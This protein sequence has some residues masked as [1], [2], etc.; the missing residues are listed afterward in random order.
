MGLKNKVLNL[1]NKKDIENIQK[2]TTNDTK[3]NKTSFEIVDNNNYRIKADIKKWRYALNL[4][5]DIKYPNRYNLYQ[6]YDE[7]MLDPIVVNA[8]DLR[9]ERILGIPFSIVNKSG[10][11]NKKAQDVFSNYWFEKYIKFAIDSVLFGHSL[12]RIDGIDKN[13]VTDVSLIPR[14][15]IIPEFGVFKK[16]AQSNYSEAGTIDY[17]DNKIYK[18]FTEAFKSRNDVGLLNKVVVSQISKKVAQLAWTQF[19]EKFG[20]PTVI[21]RTNSNLET[22]KNDLQDFLTNLSMN[23]AAVLDK[24]TDIE[25]KETVRSD[26]YSVYKE[27]INTMNDEIN[28]AILGATELTS[29]ASG[30]SEARAKVHQ[31]QSNHKTA[32]DIRFIT[33]H[34]N[35]VLIPKLVKLK[36]IPTGLKFQFDFNEVLSMEEKITVDSQLLK[37]YKLSKDYIER[38][39]NVEI[40]DE[41]IIEEELITDETNETGETEL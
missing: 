22:E 33:N 10:K 16:D 11:V 27:L 25:F 3:L 14:E 8:I 38:V 9:T 2:T 12:I 36:V 5:E 6:I 21:G 13:G 37:Y 23:S 39:Y 1:F 26:V 40:E 4:A 35:N 29:G 20:E 32:S 7:I 28:T 41:P 30:G 15:N 18:W 17:M 31:A 34:I 24:Q 19:V